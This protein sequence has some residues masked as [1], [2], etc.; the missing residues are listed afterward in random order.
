MYTNDFMGMVM[1]PQLQPWFLRFSDK[2]K[3]PLL[4]AKH[5]NEQKA[6][7]YEQHA[8]YKVI[9]GFKE[10]YTFLMDEYKEH[11][12]FAE[13][14]KVGVISNPLL[15]KFVEMNFHHEMFLDYELKEKSLLKAFNID[16]MKVA[17]NHYSYHLT[18]LT[19]NFT[20][21]DHGM[22]LDVLGIKEGLRDKLE[23]YLTDHQSQCNCVA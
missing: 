11:P 21:L 17:L 14:K 7:D 23:D 16:M 10:I 20:Q 2:G 1:I 15:S 5:K 8:S 4:L 6:M 3:L 9:C 18:K 19:K 13:G 22:N 12:M